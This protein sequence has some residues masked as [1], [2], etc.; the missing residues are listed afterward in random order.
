M[1]TKDRLKTSNIE[2]EIRQNDRGGWEIAEP[3]SK[4]GSPFAVGN[5]DTWQ[6]A[7][8]AAACNFEKDRIRVI[9]PPAPAKAARPARSPQP[10][11]RHVRPAR[12]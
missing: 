3:G 5:Y 4:P 2:A 12:A 9:H 11:T 1:P 8:A 10:T 7:F 6:H